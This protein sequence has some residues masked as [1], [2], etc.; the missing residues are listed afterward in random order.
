MNTKTI[1]QEEIDTTKNNLKSWIVKI[2][3]V[4]AILLMDI[5]YIS[6][7]S[8]RLYYIILFVPPWD[9]SQ[10]ALSWTIIHTDS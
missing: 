4:I 10:A 7:N 9:W 8:L 6:L 2:I 5:L 3:A 1:N